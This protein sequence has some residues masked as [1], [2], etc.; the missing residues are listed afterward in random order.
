MY[1]VGRKHRLQADARCFFEQAVA[2][3][4]RILTS[5]EVMQELLHAYIPVGRV[6]ALDAALE[7]VARSVVEVWPLEA[8]DVEL[9]RQL[10][11]QFPELGAR[12]LCHIASCRRRGVS[13]IKTFDRGMAVAAGRFL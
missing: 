2:R 5:A 9:A 11:D 13:E 4:L 8:A 3:H 1:A 10:Y 12:D 7:L 6:T